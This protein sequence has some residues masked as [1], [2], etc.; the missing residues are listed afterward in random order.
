DPPLAVGRIWYRS[1]LDRISYSPDGVNIR[2]IPPSPIGS[3][4]IAD[5]AITTAKIADAA[6]TSAKIAD[7]SITTSKIADASITPPKIKSVTTP[8]DGYVLSYDA[9]S[10]LFKW[11]ASAGGVSS[12][13]QLIID[14][15]KDWGGHVIKNLGTPV[16]PGDSLRLQDLTSHKNASP[17]D[18]PD[19][20]ITTA[21]IADG[22]VTRA[23]LEYP[24]SNVSF[25][26]LAAIDKVMYVSFGTW[27][28]RV[29]TRDS[30]TDKAVFAAVQ[31]NAYPAVFARVQDYNNS[32]ESLYNPAAST[33]DH[34]IEKLS[35][36]SFT[37]LATESIDIDTKGRG[38]A[39]SVVG[40]TIK[41]MRFELL[42]AVDPLNLPT[43][44][45][46]ITATD[47]TFT[48]G[49]F[50]YRVLRET[51]PH[52]GTTPDAVYLKAPMSPSPQ[53]IAYFE[54]PVTG[55][56][57][58][59]DPFRAQMPELIEWDWSINLLAKKKYDILRSKGFTDE[60]ILALFPELQCCRANRLS[61]TH[62]AL[63]KTDR[64]TGKPIDYVAIVRVF[65]QPNRQAHLHPI[66]GALDSLRSM[67]GVRRL[68]REEAIRRAKQ[69]DPDLT[70]VDLIPIP[71][72]HPNFRQILKDYIEHRKGLGVR[73]DLID[74][75][76]M[77]QYL[78]EDKGW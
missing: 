45:A 68:S 5:G 49:R 71:S 2:R 10:G 62:S 30:F 74:E 63:I 55:S 1:D 13:S 37:T 34:F 18:H 15:D 51:Y 56:G 41:S 26:Y 29:L 20:S 60:E 31:V 12:L 28:V 59:D 9:S 54:V 50:G 7:G 61:L 24:T 21:K 19:G 44:N 72:T 43:P 66:S 17:I 33:A 32:Y 4:D 40:S 39:I 52:G 77:E 78:Q 67:K 22:N 64:A 27:G 35:A 58:P 48:S 76:L 25:A 6:V 70:D 57:T 75:K 16:D 73:E 11:V 38:L 23:K 46:T 3:S 47:T 8:S 53:P 69:I 14:V 42:S 65:D 36:G